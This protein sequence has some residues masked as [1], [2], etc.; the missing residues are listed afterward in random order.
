MKIEI[1]ER[2]I[3]KNEPCFII[4]E[5]GVNHNGNIDIAKKL[6]ESAADAGADAVKF[7]TFEAKDLVTEKGEMASYQKKNLQEKKSQFEMLKNY[8]LSKGDFVDLKKYCEH[9]GIIFLSTPHTEKAVDFLEDLVPLYKIASG[10]INNIPLLRKVS[11]KGKPVI[12]SSG[13][14]NL[15]ETKFGIETVKNQGNDKIITLHCTT[16]YPCPMNEVN[17]NSMLT[18]MDELDC[19]VGYSDHTLGL[20]IP[21]CARAMGA[22]VIEKHFTLN[23]KME[24]PDHKASLNPEE[25]KFMVSSIRNIELSFGS[26]VKQANESEKQI[27]KNVRKSLVASK[28][29]E[30]GKIIS[31]EDIS[32]K[33]PA[34]G[35]DPTYYDNIVGKK[36]LKPISKDEQF[37]YKYLA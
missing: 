8:E 34:T 30:K 2:Y 6:I 17:M 14:A 28:Y 32:V 4:A 25:L 7:Q 11:N 18:M 31:E 22:S 10:D 1:N 3:G 33:R 5:A 19:L 16:N 29:L 26:Y 27:M 21:I 15:E 35:F 12:L 13:M 36:L 23:K 9:K 24:G 37:S 20:E